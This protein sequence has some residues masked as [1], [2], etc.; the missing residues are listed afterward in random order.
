MS[1]GCLGAVLGPSWGG[2]SAVLATDEGRLWGVFGR[3]GASRPF[4]GAFGARFSHQTEAAHLGYDFEF[5][6]TRFYT[7][8]SIIGTHE[9]AFW[10][11]KNSSFEPSGHFN[12]KLLQDVFLEPTCLHVPLQKAPKSRFGGVLTRLGSV[13]GRKV[14]PKS[15]PKRHREI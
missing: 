4:F 14:I 9:T 8:F 13:L 3:S 7:D 10:Y 11:Y 5:D 2:L 12:R 1:W 6:F 15:I